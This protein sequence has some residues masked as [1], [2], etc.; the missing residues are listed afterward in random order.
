MG[1]IMR[2]TSVKKA[3]LVEKYI[4]NKQYRT[5]VM[6]CLSKVIEDLKPS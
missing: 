6:N 3:P 2:S 5:I 4:N 1:I